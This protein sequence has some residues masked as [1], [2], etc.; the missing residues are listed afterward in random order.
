MAAEGRPNGP[1]VSDSLRPRPE[2]RA[3]RPPS[4]AAVLLAN[5]IAATNAA[6]DDAEARYQST[7]EALRK[8][9]DEVVVEIARA[10]GRCEETDYPTRLALVQAASQLRRPSALA[11]LRTLVLT[12]I[13]AE[14]SPD[15]HS[16]SSVG[17]ETIL[18][19]I[20]VEGVGA[21]AADGDKKALAALFEFL[22]IP[23]RSVRRAAVQS[24]YAAPRGRGLR[25]RMEAALPASQHFLLDLQP[26]EVGQ[27][28]QVKRPQR[29][30]STAGR[31]SKTPPAPGLGD[32]E[33]RQASA[34]SPPPRRGA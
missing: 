22:E 10:E 20:A 21:L 12:P 24:I 27:A 30:L 8:R 4:P 28:P 15:P 9:A 17:E 26:I 7:L 13:P 34:S 16:F 19:T 2:A 23:S 32:D 18:R 3:E 14:R 33:G 6:G 11:F 31:K 29:H 25:K 1:R 5:F